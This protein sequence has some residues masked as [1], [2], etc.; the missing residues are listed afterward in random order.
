MKNCLLKLLAVFMALFT[1]SSCEPEDLVGNIDITIDGSTYHIPV[2]VFYAE[3]NDTYI[4]G[5]NIKQSVT[6]KLEDVEVGKKTLGLG[7]TL[8]SAATNLDKIDDMKNTLVYIPTSGIT[9]DGMTA[10]YGTITITKATKSI[11]EGTFEGGGVK[12][13]VLQSLSNLDYDNFEDNVV[14]FSGSFSAVGRKK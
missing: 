7:K 1:F 9:E 12:T 2:A 3:G 14:K 11:V 10:M 6:F 4:A 5:T 8:Y 13:S